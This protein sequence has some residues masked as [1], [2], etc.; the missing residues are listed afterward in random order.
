MQRRDF[1]PAVMSAMLAGGI[2][3]A[4]DPAAAMLEQKR[5]LAERMAAARGGEMAARI[6]IML[7]QAREAAQAGNIGDA[8]AMV[9]QAMRLLAAAA[10]PQ[11]STP[12][13]DRGRYNQLLDRIG[14]YR[15]S[16]DAEVRAGLASAGLLDQPRLDA[17]M[18]RA[19]AAAR[20]GRY[21]EASALAEEAAAMVER[22]IIDAR[23]GQTVVAALNFAGPQ[24]EYAYEVNRH[25]SYV[26]L[27]RQT[28]DEGR[29]GDH[30]LQIL[31]LSEEAAHLRAEAEKKA[32]AG[33]WKAAV[34]GM[35]TATKPLIRA[36]QVMGLP[37]PE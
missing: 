27:V 15:T 14:Q 21:D 29:G 37:I 22:L 12:E 19:A 4:A 28:A 25:R 32:A 8:E 1:L 9:G 31:A 23:N 10:P 11:V 26:L 17:Q 13:A 6:E 5:L 24:D 33:D 34:R 35:E 16:F 36:L 3:E 2:A 30:G 18:A 20:G 7:K